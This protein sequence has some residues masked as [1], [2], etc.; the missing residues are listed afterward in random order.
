MKNPSLS[1]GTRFPVGAQTSSRPVHGR[2]RFLITNEEKPQRGRAEAAP[3]EGCRVGETQHAK[4]I[5]N[6]FLNV[7]LF[8]SNFIHRLTRPWPTVALS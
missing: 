4:T 1:A 5:E 8:I 6:L 2:E 3:K 7:P